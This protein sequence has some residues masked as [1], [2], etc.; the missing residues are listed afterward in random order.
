MSYIKFLA[1]IYLSAEKMSRNLLNSF[2][3]F[4]RFTLNKNERNRFFA[5]V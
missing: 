1:P 2:P 3:S 4:F 5:V